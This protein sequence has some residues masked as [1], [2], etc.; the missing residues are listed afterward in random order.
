MA[1][2]WVD[3]TLLSNPLGGSSAVLTPALL[4][5]LLLQTSS[6]PLDEVP[7]GVADA[8][9]AHI[10]LVV[11]VMCCCARVDM[12]CTRVDGDA[13]PAPMQCPALH[14]TLE[15]LT[16]HPSPQQ[17]L[18]LLHAQPVYVLLPMRVN[19]CACV[20]CRPLSTRGFRWWVCLTSC[21]P[22]SS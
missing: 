19:L 22:H 21:T 4:L 11:S 18:A 13:A 8:E 6:L 2:A 17:L 1:V 12:D 7:A 15:R 5:L 3:L 20:S 16:L 10:V 9:A 14:P